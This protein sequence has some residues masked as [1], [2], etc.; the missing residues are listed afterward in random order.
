LLLGHSSSSSFPGLLSL[1]R[2]I[3][4]AVMGGGDWFIEIYSVLENSSLKFKCL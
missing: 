4:I 3:T 1:C 2:S